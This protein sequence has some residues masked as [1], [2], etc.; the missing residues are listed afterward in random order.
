MADK[1]SSLPSTVTRSDNVA[2][3][4]IFVTSFIVFLMIAIIAQTLTWHWRDWLPGAEGEKSLIGG[5]KAAVYTFMSHL[6]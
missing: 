3:A 4:G 1:T 5:V 6:T 2:F